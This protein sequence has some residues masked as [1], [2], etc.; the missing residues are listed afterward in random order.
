G[1]KLIFRVGAQAEGG[2]MFAQIDFA[3]DGPAVSSFAAGPERIRDLLEREG[4]IPAPYRARI[5]WVALE[6]W[7]V[8]R[9]G[10][11]EDLLRRA[12]GLTYAK[13]PKRTRDLLAAPGGA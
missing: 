8:F 5:H 11:L 10:E 13:L 1:D 12:H 4:V 9:R 2:K 6:H 3:E 7:D